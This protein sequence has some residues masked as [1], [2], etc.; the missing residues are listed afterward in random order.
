MATIRLDIL[1]K[2][3]RDILPLGGGMS[4]TQPSTASAAPTFWANHFPEGTLPLGAVHEF[5]GQEQEGLAATTGFMAALISTFLP[6]Q[7]IMAWISPDPLV[8]PPAL[9]RFGISPEQV[10]FIH[11]SSEKDLLWTVDE[12]LKCTGLSAVVAEIKKLESMTSRRLQL[13]VEKSRVTGFMLNR[14]KP[15]TNA[16]VSRWMIKSMPSTTQ[17]DLPGLGEPHWDVELQ[18]IR[19]GRPGKWTISWTGESLIRIAPA[20]IQ[21]PDYQEHRH[22]G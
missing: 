14:G 16:C 15:Q 13:A 12:A 8:F 9:L 7:G 20:G 6:R 19:N 5:I 1:Q 3:R 17:D 22:T 10:I 11:P 21:V 4:K 2:L 18:K